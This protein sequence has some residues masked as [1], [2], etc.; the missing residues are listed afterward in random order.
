MPA[1]EALALKFPYTD[2]LW[3]IGFTL[4]AKADRLPVAIPTDEGM[5]VTNFELLALPERGEARRLF[6]G[7]GSAKSEVKSN[8][9]LERLQAERDRGDSSL[10]DL[11]TEK[12]A[13][14]LF[15]MLLAAAPQVRRPV[16]TNAL[17]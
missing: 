8:L 14:N 13:V 2:H 12:C 5:L 17:G 1:I 4:K 3:Q 16:T 7:K 11:Y 6:A 9:P 10:K 15:E